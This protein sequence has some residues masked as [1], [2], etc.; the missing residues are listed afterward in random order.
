MK[1]TKFDKYKG[2]YEQLGSSF[3]NIPDPTLKSLA[4]SWENYFE[5]MEALMSIPSNKITKSALAAGLEQGLM[6]TYDIIAEIPE[7]FRVRATT[8][9]NEA[10]SDHFPGFMAEIDKKCE[11]ILNRGKIR[12]ESECHLLRS[13]VDR[14][15]FDQKESSVIDSYQKLLDDFEI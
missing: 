3:R 9:F 15:S 7:E 13:K 11:K 2:L 6:E 14:L 4:D 12:N 1:K 10:C 8:A 5:E